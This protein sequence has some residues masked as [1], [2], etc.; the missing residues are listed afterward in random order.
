MPSTFN[1]KNLYNSYGS[2]SFKE[3][4]YGNLDIHIAWMLFSKISKLGNKIAFIVIIKF[5]LLKLQKSVN[6]LSVDT[7]EETIRI[8]QRKKKKSRK[9][10]WK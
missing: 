7:R 5:C 8:I 2:L 3:I 9:P 10:E 6:L 1:F 4:V